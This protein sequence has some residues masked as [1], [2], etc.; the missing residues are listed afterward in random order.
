[1]I[2]GDG[3]KRI[4]QKVQLLPSLLLGEELTPLM[5]RQVIEPRYY[6]LSQEILPSGNQL[7]FSYDAKGHLISVEMKNKALTKTFSWIHLTYEFQ[8]TG[9]QVHIETSDAR[10]LAYHFAW[11]NGLYQLIQ[12]EGSHCMPVTYE[13]NGSFS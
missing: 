7:F 1:M 8:D 9:C 10:K 2:L 12:V 11:D 4:Y 6:L 5:A 3:T 13:Y